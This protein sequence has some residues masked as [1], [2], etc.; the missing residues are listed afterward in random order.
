[1]PPPPV[2]TYRQGVVR[3]DRQALGRAIADTIR[4]QHWVQDAYVIPGIGLVARSNRH[5]EF[6]VLWAL[7]RLVVRM[8]LCRRYGGVFVV[9]RGGSYG[10]PLDDDPDQIGQAAADW[11]LSR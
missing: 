6:S 1:M 7:D 4:G 2:G 5:I 10:Y 11:F 9:K 3:A 8:A